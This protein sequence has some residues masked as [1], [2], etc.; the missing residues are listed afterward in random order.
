MFD[1]DDLVFIWIGSNDLDNALSNNP[2]ILF[3]PMAMEE[4]YMNVTKNIIDGINLLVSRGYP[5]HSM[6]PPMHVYC[7]KPP[8]HLELGGGGGWHKALVVGSVSLWRRVLAS[9]P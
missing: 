8:P 3:N 6:D 9:H 7:T 5:S 2:A 4:L 1:A